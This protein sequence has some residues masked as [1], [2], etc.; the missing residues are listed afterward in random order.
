MKASYLLK[1]NIR[2]LLSARGQT[3]H[4]LA[5][6]CRKT[7][8]WVSK[9]LS[10][11]PPPPGEKERGI[12]LKYLDRIADFFGIATYQLFQPGIS[13]L[14]ER[15]G[16][17]D[18]RGG[19]DRRISGRQQEIVA[20]PI[21]ALTLTADDEAML[22]ELHAL[23]YEQYQHVKAWIAV[24]RFGPHSERNRTPPD[25]PLL[26]APPPSRQAPRTRAVRPQT[27]RAAKR[28]EP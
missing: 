28:M 20:T 6:W 22:A 23:S 26:A 21:R 12:P 16:G 2:T 19:R 24:A 7:D 17:K 27:P 25:A 9:I 10:D 11:K 8:P 14:T 1:R 18:R 5:V 3:A 15:R 13:P 4:D